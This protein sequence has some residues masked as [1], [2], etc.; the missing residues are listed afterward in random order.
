MRALAVLVVLIC[1]AAAHPLEGAAKPQLVAQLGHSAE[2]YSVAASRDGSQVASTAEDCTIKLWKV[3]SG[4]LLRTI[5]MPDC[6]ISNLALS[7]DGRLLA[8]L[9]IDG[10]IRF[11][12][13]Q[14]GSNVRT[15]RTDLWS[16]TVAS[17]AFSPDCSL[18]ACADGKQVT[19]WDANLGRR[20]HAVQALATNLAFSPSGLTLAAGCGSEIRFWAMP[21]FREMRLLRR[22][23]THEVTGITYGSDGRLL[24]QDGYGLQLWDPLK[25]RLVRK[26]APGSYRSIG[27]STECVETVT[28]FTTFRESGMSDAEYG[29]YGHRWRVSR[30]QQEWIQLLVCNSNER[31]EALSV[32]L[33]P[34]DS[35]STAFSGDHRTLLSL[36]AHD[37]KATIWDVATAKAKGSIAV[38][39][40]VAWPVPALNF[41][42]S[43]LAVSGYDSVVIVDL[44][45]KKPVC[46]IKL[47][48]SYSD[49]VATA[50]NK[51][52]SILA[53][54]GDDGSVALWRISD[55]ILWRR[56]SG[57]PIPTLPNAVST[58]QKRRTMQKP[59]ASSI[60]SLAFSGDN[61]LAVSRRDGRVEIVD[62]NAS[63]GCRILRDGGPRITDLSFS[64]NGEYVAGQDSKGTVAVWRVSTGESAGTFQGSNDRII[65]FGFGRDNSMLTISTA[66]GVVALYHL[67]SGTQA[68]TL[69][70]HMCSITSCGFSR[71]LRLVYSAHAD[72]SIQVFDSTTGKLVFSARSLGTG[73]G[74][75]SAR[76]TANDT[77]VWNEGSVL[78]RW[79]PGTEVYPSDF[80]QV[81]NPIRSLAL[82]SQCSIAIGDDRG[83]VRIL[84]PESRLNWLIRGGKP[85]ACMAFAPDGSSLAVGRSDHLGSSWES[86]GNTDPSASDSL[87]VWRLP[88]D[89]SCRVLAQNGEIDCVAFTPD[90]SKLMTLC[91]GSWQ[92]RSLSTAQVADSM[93]SEAPGWV[94]ILATQRSHGSDYTS[95]LDSFHSV[96]VQSASIDAQS[97]VAVTGCE[98][99]MAKGYE[100]GTR[101]GLVRV[102]DTHD[103]VI[104]K[105]IRLPEPVRLIAIGPGGRTASCLCETPTTNV[106]RLRMIDLLSGTT[107]CTCNLPL[108]W[109]GAIA[110]DSK[111]ERLLLGNYDGTVSVWSLQKGSCRQL[112][113]IYVYTDGSWAVIDNDG[114]YDGSNGGDVP[115][116]HWVVGTE[117]IELSQLKERYY[118]PGLLAKMMGQSAEPLRDVSKLED[119]KLYPGM[120]ISG[121][122]NGSSVMKVRL[123]NRG[124][125]I[126]RV[127]V[128]V[129][130]KEVSADARGEKPDPD[131]AAADLRIDLDRYQSLLD[132]GKPNEIKVVCYNS[133][134][135]NGRRDEYLASRGSSTFYRPVGEKA[136]AKPVLWAIVGGITEYAGG[137]SMRLRYSSKDAE[138]M[139]KALEVGGHRLFG[140]GNVRI[141][142][143][144]DSKIPSAITPSK[145][146]FARAFGEAKRAKPGDVV[147]VYL[148]GHGIALA[149][150]NSTYCYLTNDATSTDKSR[151]SDPGY[152]SQSAITSGELARWANDIPAVHQV[153]ILDTCAAGA[154]A[155]DLSGSRDISG[156]QIRAIER[157][158]DR[159]GFWVLMG[160]ASDAVSYEASRYGQG[161]L[162]YS[163]LEY[164]R[165]EKLREDKFVDVNQMFNY[166]KDRVPE[167][168]GGVGGIQKPKI[169]NP[170][171]RSAALGDVSTFD[172]GMLDIQDRAL[173]PLPTERPIVLRP[174]ITCPNEG[175]DVLGLAPQVRRRLMEMEYSSTRQGTEIKTPVYVDA[176][177]LPG[178]VRVEGFY[179]LTGSQ[180]TT[181]LFFWRDG[182]KTA[183]TEVTGARNDVPGIAEKLVSAI[184]DALS[185]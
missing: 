58:G 185:R 173:I 168:A 34:R 101:C 120:S 109:V 16:E 93:K 5:R 88:P 125:G 77:V 99:D 103:G 136:R 178:A 69:Y 140:V 144:A 36:D 135:R 39:K 38:A 112:G 19:I 53:S 89:G 180:A 176:E 100:L 137:E 134:L 59:L 14:T 118:D 43:M 55:G 94:E 130:G 105:S 15:I 18:I 81:P 30:Q 61:V 147:V 163:L 167:L 131:A 28:G 157:L 73:F 181:K 127:Q 62:C 47:S 143:L 95:P 132:P 97:N 8:A 151:L 51:S 26:Y 158:K 31:R 12:N 44:V 92:T 3:S 50:L 183:E 122:A 150:D 45:S 129:N 22:R 6:A 153:M 67:Q 123:V 124:G 32:D 70:G 102:W 117:P 148:A 91:D 96:L 54:A 72:G 75:V 104:S 149:Q 111:C 138:A 82:D 42:G 98:E 152:R 169:A 52:G 20:L 172:I 179:S 155:T 37:G 80:A 145:V 160:C 87:V 13:T 139:A 33:G 114:R 159:T 128:L 116:L 1:L 156:D 78:R 108:C 29:N 133:V 17:L 68:G 79:R 76:W 107:I 63:N 171:T 85:A 113:M 41:D 161:L 184:E 166:A 182:K 35:T 126:G 74:R 141:K 174:A 46:T 27:A 7:P 57:P 60:V 164:L 142:L 154:V 25:A 64:V 86:R 175:G 24:V 106:Q 48:S 71:D 10:C 121:P 84:A 170:R 165:I 90:G 119:V 9:G 146:N 115:Y 66:D 56:I 162:T 21:S 65:S 2:I 11:W 83:N 177:E 49:R 4:E 40:E 23:F 110:T